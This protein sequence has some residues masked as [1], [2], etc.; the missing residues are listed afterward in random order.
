MKKYQ[1]IAKAIKLAAGEF[2]FVTAMGHDIFDSADDIENMTVAEA[3]SNVHAQCGMIQVIYDLKFG[4]VM[5]LV[6]KFYGEASE[7]GVHV[8]NY[9]DV[10]DETIIEWM[11]E[12]EA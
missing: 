4:D 12:A 3:I 11:E 8:N 6:R 10:S 9:D 7:R 5:Y 1:N 2:S